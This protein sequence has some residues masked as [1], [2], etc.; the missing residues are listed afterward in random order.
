MSNRNFEA[1]DAKNKTFKKYSRPAN[2][3]SIIWS[4]LSG[5]GHAALAL[6]IHHTKSIA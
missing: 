4:G 1:R 5:M 3:L 6:L 2:I